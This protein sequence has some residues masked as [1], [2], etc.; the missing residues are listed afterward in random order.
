MRLLTLDPEH[1]ERAPIE[2]AAALIRAGG[3]VAFPTETVYGLGANALN[4]E[5]IERIFAAKGRPAYNPLIAHAADVAAAR[6]LSADW[7]SAA[8]RL[9]EAFWPGPLTLVVPKRPEIP[10]RLTAGLPTVALRVPRH[11]VASALLRA[12]GVP[13]AAPSANPFTRLSPTL[14]SHVTK[15]LGDRVD[16][17]LDA[18]PASLGIE[19]T[20]VDVSGERPVLL[21]PGS[22]SAR[23]LEEVLGE[24]LANAGTL[25]GEMPR[26]GPGMVAKH[27]SPRAR[28]LLLP[29]EENLDFG[30]L[31]R[32]AG[33]GGRTTGLVL[34]EG[35]TLTGGTA[36]SRLAPGRR[37]SAAGGRGS[38]PDAPGSTAGSRGGSPTYSFD[39][40]PADSGTII[41]ELP[42]D[43]EGYARELYA[44]LHTLDDA[45][46]DTIFVAPIPADG[47]WAGVRDRLRRAS[48][49][50]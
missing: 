15:G 4:P 32:E 25:A 6:A 50:G 39:G 22:I 26:P 45:G 28:L 20:V 17:V 11:P 44:A 29:D 49:R 12:A 36:G 8:E 46:C 21:R 19:S 9:A 34:L 2:E 18:G 3:L 33:G 10:A 38:A 27:Y 43:P 35:D 31:L 48:H 7:S 24:P 23:A 42:A 14:A 30:A 5:A 16:L 40:D 47:A 37:G 13:I 41:I 1:P